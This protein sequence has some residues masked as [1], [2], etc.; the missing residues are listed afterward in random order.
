MS[1]VSF[2]P[3]KRTK[4]GHSR[5]VMQRDVHRW[6]CLSPTGGFARLL[7]ALLVCWGFVACTSPQTPR[8]ASPLP[9]GQEVPSRFYDPARPC[10]TKR[11]MARARK[12]LFTGY[13]RPHQKRWLDALNRAFFELRAGCNDSDFLVL[14]LTTIQLESGVEV[15][16][17][18]GNTNLGA[19]FVLRLQRFKEY[20]TL[21]GLL[22]NYSGLEEAL[23]SKLRR[24]TKRG[25]VRREGDLVRYIEEDLRPWVQAYLEE[26][27]YLPETLARLVVE[28]GISNPIRTL[29]PM[30][31]NVLKAYRNARKRGERVES[32]QV[33]RQWLLAPDTALQRGLKEGIDLLRQSYRFYRKRLQREQAILFSGVD[34]NAGEFSSRN[35][36]FQEMV[37]R[38]T[39]KPQVLDGDLLWYEDGE[40]IRRRSEIEEAVM[41]LFPHEPPESIRKD[42][43]REKE[44]A[45]SS[46]RTWQRVCA[47][48][49]AKAKGPCLLARLPAGAENVT[50]RI[51]LGR[52]Y[53]PVNYGRAV[54]HR[55]R[56]NRRVYDKG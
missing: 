32:P 16:P 15:N 17:R 2:P 24:D 22:L 37:A 29:G 43:L 23:R 21:A 20:H 13:P 14:V 47:R 48:F 55:F 44:A 42:L 36:A 38:V 10:F 8:K 33:M 35:A 54:L 56:I 53:S 46:T 11:Q 49:R 52:P 26:T 50:A 31:V 27:Y 30:Q 41:A 51:K 5:K 1:W 34:F 4:S 3:P 25:F 28:L 45:F 19:M 40:P 12:T 7:V 9:R 39:G 6:R 18:L